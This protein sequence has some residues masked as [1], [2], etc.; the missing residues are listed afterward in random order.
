MIVL[1][2]VEVNKCAIITE[3]VELLS[4]GKQIESVGPSAAS[5]L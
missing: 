3:K 1:D 4:Q 2:K 5:L